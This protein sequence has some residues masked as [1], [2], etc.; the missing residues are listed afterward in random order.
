MAQMREQRDSDAVIKQ[1]YQRKSFQECCLFLLSNSENGVLTVFYVLMS[2]CAKI[3][4]FD[5]NLCKK[6][7]Q[8]TCMS[9]YGLFLAYMSNT[10]AMRSEITEQRIA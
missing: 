1:S 9:I 5:R 3:F 4:V 7:E 2:R 6:R 10:E 8:L